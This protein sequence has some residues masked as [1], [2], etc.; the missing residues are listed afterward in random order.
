MHFAQPHFDQP[1]ALLDRLTGDEAAYRQKWPTPERWN[2]RR[3]AQKAGLSEGWEKV[4]RDLKGWIALEK[5]QAPLIGVMGL[6]NAG[7]SSLIASLLSAEGAARVLCGEGDGQGTQRF[8]FWLP[9]SWRHEPAIYEALREELAS[10]FGASVEPLSED[11]AE[12]HRQYNGS[13]AIEASFGIPLLAFDRRLD[14]VGFGFLDCPDFERRHPGAPGEATARVRLAFVQKAARLMSA[15]VIVADRAKVATELLY[16]F[17]DRGLEWSGKPRF[18]LVNQLRPSEAPDTLLKDGGIRD[19]MHRVGID[20][21]YVAYHFEMVGARNKI[22]LAA[23]AA[24]GL[25]EHD[26]VFFRVGGEP[27]ENRPEAIGSDRLIGDALAR[28]DASELWNDRKELRRLSVRQGVEALRAGIAE[29]LDREEGDLRTLRSGLLGF[30]RDCVTSH[31]NELK[32]PASAI[33]AQLASVMVEVAPL[34][35]KPTLWMGGWVRGVKELLAGTYGQARQLYRRISQP[36]EAL[37]EKTKAFRARLAGD[38]GDLIHPVELTARSKNARWMPEEVDEAQLTAAWTEVLNRVETME[39]ALPEEE[40]CAFAREIWTAVPLS[41]KVAFVATG[42]L[43]LVGGLVAVCLLPLDFGGSAVVFAASL[44]ELLTTLGV[45]ATLTGMAGAALQRSIDERVAVPFYL[46]L[47]RAA[48]D[49]FGLPRGLDEP[50]H[51]RFANVGEVEAPLSEKGEPLPEPP[52]FPLAPTHF[53]A[54]EEA[55]FWGS[56]KVSKERSGG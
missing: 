50:F 47:L 34:W 53:L 31:R 1:E 21:L 4:E 25:S 9:E 56:A 10:V 46:R 41:K 23:A 13:G 38:E 44:S 29:R 28:L 54:E 22:P 30:L 7:K 15:L 32:F 42:P 26:P 51:D 36:G 40:V 55:A 19:M 52:L 45:A 5:A 8:V 6:L 24:H 16:T 3:G 18:L 48:L 2:V 27:G 37:L 33:A 20:E 43:V 39:A 49:V 35:A 12:A 11:P 14:D 17:A